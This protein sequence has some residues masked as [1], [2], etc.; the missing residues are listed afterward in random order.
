[1]GRVDSALPD[2]SVVPAVRPSPET[3][4]SGVANGLSRPAVR[5]PVALLAFLLLSGLTSY[6]SV[7]WTR[8]DGGVAVLWMSNGL[9]A[10]ALLLVPNGRWLRWALASALGQ[11]GAR[12]VLGNA[13]A[14]VAGLTLANLVECWIAAGWIRRRVSD[15]GDMGAL[16]PLSRAALTG[17]LLACA[18]SATLAMPVVAGALKQSNDVIWLTWFSAHVL[19]MVIVGTL[20]LCLAQMRG[21][22]LGRRGRRLD[23]AACVAL[24]VGVSVGIDLQRALPLLFLAYLPLLLLTW[25]H[26]LAGVVW[27]ILVLTLT[28]AAAA[29]DHFGQFALQAPDAA[30][31]RTLLLQVYVAAGC[32]LAIPT[33]VAM[34]ERRWLDR[35]LRQSEARLQAVTDNVPAMVSYF[36]TQCRFTYANAVA[37]RSVG[38]DPSRLLGR[39]LREV[40]GDATWRLL[41]PRMA[42]ALRGEPQVFEAQTDVLGTPMDYRAHYVP[43]RAAD[44]S[45]VGFYSFGFDITQA[46][47]TERALEQLARF[48]S[49]TGLANR[50]H[51]EEDLDR[52]VVRA[53]RNHSP[54]LLLA[55]DVDRFKEINDSFGH[56]AGDAVLRA[57]AQRIREVVYDVDLVARVG[58]DEFVVLVEYS[59]TPGVGAMVAA[60]IVAAMAEP[61]QVGDTRLPVRASIGVGFQADVAGA[62]ALRELADLALY[63]AKRAGRDGW[64]LRSG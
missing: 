51:F 38:G 18:V 20:L 42:A 57:F 47:Q 53:H 25:R 46:K 39:T 43:D 31:A 9:L 23:L 6:A 63:D 2:P 1:M 24:L 11:V 27:G 5:E 35:K 44:G 41:E 59:P 29:F 61:M 21:S 60:R 64:A 37:L 34:T 40:R 17:T 10:S 8:I 19:G 52:A 13:L 56:A 48:D 33:A 26:G 3:A 30:L 36:D 50:R 62:S 15:F 14:V 49:L 54:L 32:L 22:L 12:L 55:I 45:V 28:S 7:A 16:V 4:A 58:G